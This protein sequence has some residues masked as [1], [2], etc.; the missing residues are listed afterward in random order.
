MPT[1]QKASFVESPRRIEDRP[2]AVNR[3]DWP[4]TV[5]S[6]EDAWPLYV[7]HVAQSL[8]VEIEKRFVLDSR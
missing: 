1:H 2:T 8:A 5:L 6:P 7:A 3:P 4:T